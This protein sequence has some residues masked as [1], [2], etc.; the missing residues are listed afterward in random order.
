MDVALEQIRQNSASVDAFVKR[1]YRWFNAFKV[2]KY[3]HFVRDNQL[4]QPEPIEVAA[5]N[6][7]QVSLKSTKSCCCFTECKIKK[8]ETFPI[9]AFSICSKVAYFVA[10]A[11]LVVA[12]FAAGF[13][14]AAAFLEQLS[15]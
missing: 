9:R 8:P 2:L 3:V 15:F 6:L 11:F 7:L 4:Y 13:L 1:F 14:A 5:R 12:F 10:A